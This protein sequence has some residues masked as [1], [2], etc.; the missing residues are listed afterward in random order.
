MVEALPSHKTGYPR[1]E[2]C[3]QNASRRLLLRQWDLHANEGDKHNLIMVGAVAL[4][5]L[6]EW[7]HVASDY[8][9]VAVQ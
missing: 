9:G 7:Q 5:W 3:R 4:G 2:I 8:D 1:S 6:E